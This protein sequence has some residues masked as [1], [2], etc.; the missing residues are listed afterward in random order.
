MLQESE[1]LGKL[2]L[3]S[4]SHEI[5][6]PIAAIASAARMLKEAHD[7]SFTSVPWAMVDE[8]QEATRRL[9]RLVSNLLNLT[10]LESGHVK[11]N[12]AWCDVE[13]LI[14]G[15]LKEIERDFAC[16]KVTPE[17]AENIPFERLD[18]VLMQQVLTNLLLNAVAHT[19][20]E[21]SIQVRASAQDGMLTISVL[22]DG[23]GLPRHALPFIFD[24]FYRAPSARTGGT[25]LGLAIVK[26]LVE[27]QGGHVE[28]A[29]RPEGGAAFRIRLPVSKPPPVLSEA[30]MRARS[31]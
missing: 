25:G 1:R 9:N 4:V 5:R 14:H 15:T 22:D 30:P 17:I 7:P 2:L 23:P 31:F 28:A 27:A 12:L 3:D 26:G 20:A 11:S 8:I 10:R 6:T 13:D 18:F 19:P 29:N 21:T 16:R 24:K